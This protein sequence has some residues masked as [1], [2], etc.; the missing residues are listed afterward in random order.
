MNNKYHKGLVLNNLRALRNKLSLRQIDSATIFGF[1]IIDRISHWEKGR[2][3]PGLINTI[4]LCKLY[5]A[6]TIDE[7]Y[8]ELCK[9][10]EEEIQENMNR[11]FLRKEEDSSDTLH[12]A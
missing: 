11:N 8:P 9:Q 1:E 5:G 2:S 3:Q 6:K 4:R 12:T 7:L 10:I